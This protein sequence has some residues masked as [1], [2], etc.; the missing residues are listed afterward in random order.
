MIDYNIWNRWYL[1]SKERYDSEVNE[2]SGGHIFPVEPSPEFLNHNEPM[3]TIRKLRYLCLKQKP[4]QFY[5]DNNLSEIFLK[6]KNKT[7]IRELPFDCFFINANL[8]DGYKGLLIH[9]TTR[10]N[11]GDDINIHIRN[12]D[13]GLFTNIYFSQY[14][15]RVKNGVMP[16]IYGK[17]GLNTSSK[18]EMT[19]FEKTIKNS[20]N[21]IKWVCN[22]LDAIN[23]PDVEMIKI[24]L[25]FNNDESRI[26]RGKAPQ[27]SMI[28]NLKISGKL[29][30]Y[31]SESSGKTSIQMQQAF[32]VRGHYIHFRDKKKWNKIYLLT[33]EK[34]R[35]GGY[36]IGIKGIIAKWKF[37]FIKCKG[38]GK[39]I[40]K[41]YQLKRK[42][43][44][45][46]N[47]TSQIHGEENNG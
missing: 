38:M 23:H 42:R 11:Y 18:D 13:D 47:I 19:K 30:K 8:G 43:E 28:V 36:S 31:I 6:T 25:D 17:K 12:E 24:K 37:P 21:I 35:Q 33:D 45:I 3:I 10:D 29:Y 20:E 44:T 14:D 22:F 32:W 16:F 7:K 39:P 41:D 27:P 4:P 40:Q 1:L 5:V 46:S 15:G 9:K 26:K 34:L 2:S